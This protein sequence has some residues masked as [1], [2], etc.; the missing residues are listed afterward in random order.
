MKYITQ[1]SHLSDTAHV[2]H[3]QIYTNNKFFLNFNYLRH[4]IHIYISVYIS[5]NCF[6]F[7]CEDEAV[8]KVE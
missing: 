1:I 5:K 3:V 8:V 2:K 4:H 6:A 7:V